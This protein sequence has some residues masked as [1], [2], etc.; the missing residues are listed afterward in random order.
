MV[1]SSTAYP[2][3]PDYALNPGETLAEVIEERGMSQ[4]E[5]ARRTGL[6]T[7]HINQIIGGDASIT[8]ET[9]LR[10]EKVT[11]VPSRFW[12]SL[13]AQYRELLTRQEETVSLA[14]DVPW[15]DEL[16]IG[17]L[18][19][20]GFITR[21]TSRVDQLREVLGF[22]GVANKSAWK[23]VWATPTAYR[24]SRV[25]DVK[26]QALAAWIRIGEIR[27]EEIKAAP[28]DR[29]TLRALIPQLRALTL[30]KAKDWHPKLSTL[31]ASAGVVVV[32]EP[33][34]PGSRICGVARWIESDRALIQMSLRHKWADI[35]WFSF[36]HEIAHV[37]LHDRKRL[38]F[39]D[40]P[41]KNG[42]DDE[43]ELEANLF[44]AR[45]LIPHDTDGT[46]STLR[47]KSAI[48]EFAAS[49]AIHPGVV[50][51][52]LQHDGVLTYSQFNDLRARYEFARSD[53]D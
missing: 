45:T 50:V 9:A 32:F 31:C 41:P 46:L 28:F 21:T 39:V 33:E 14:A 52:R 18:I 30:L 20:R 6:S 1:D 25:H 16:P 34:I 2:F 29:R 35:F 40:G 48:R 38:T 8:S 13:E 49:I 26:P 47:S 19:K 53:A 43:L 5:L 37:L 3:K 27:A 24:K 7:K 51:G 36:F 44:A 17:E 4:A 15:L 23:T 11:R 12:T 42:D 22:F 10:L